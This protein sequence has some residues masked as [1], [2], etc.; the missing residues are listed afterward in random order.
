MQQRT[1]AVRPSDLALPGDCLDGA[2]KIVDAVRREL[3]QGLGGIQGQDPTAFSSIGTVYVGVLWAT[4]PPAEEPGDPGFFVYVGFEP[5]GERRTAYWESLRPGSDAPTGPTALVELFNSPRAYRWRGPEWLV[6]TRCSKF[7]ETGL[8]RVLMRC[9]GDSA[10]LGGLY[11]LRSFFAVEDAL[12]PQN[13]PEP[14]ETAWY[15]Y[16]SHA[17]ASRVGFR[18]W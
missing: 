10:V 14:P 13:H 17:T 12:V 11:C 18:C 1:A 7:F 6:R 5:D 9:L 2:Q 3:G 4:G 16:P 15:H 8:T